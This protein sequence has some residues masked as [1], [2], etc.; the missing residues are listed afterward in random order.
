MSLSFTVY[1]LNQKVTN[2]Q[3]KSHI[4]SLK[5]GFVYHLLQELR[6]NAQSLF[7]SIVAF[8]R[9]ELAA[10][11]RESE[12]ADFYMIQT[13]TPYA[14]KACLEHKDSDRVRD[15][16]RPNRQNPEKQYH[17]VVTSW[18]VWNMIREAPYNP[19]AKFIVLTQQASV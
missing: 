13:I 17:N 2:Q 9:E 19:R 5:I 11:D 14:T 1:F 6:Q 10:A 4:V 8:V 18:N 16:I 7:R 15:N 3:C 12:S